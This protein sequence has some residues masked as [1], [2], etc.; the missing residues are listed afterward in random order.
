[1]L[2]SSLVLCSL[3]IAIS[4]NEPLPEKV[5][6]VI[7]DL[8]VDLGRK[9]FK[10]WFEQVYPSHAE[11]K[12]RILGWQLDA[13]S[14]FAL[15]GQ[16]RQPL[17]LWL[18]DGHPMGATSEHGR[19]IRQALADD[20]LV[21]WLNKYS[22]AADDFNRTLDLI[23]V[24][25]GQLAVYLPNG[26]LL[27][28]E[29]ATTPQELL[30]FLTSTL[31]KYES[32]TDAEKKIESDSNILD[33]QPRAENDFPDDGLSL[34]VFKRSA[35]SLV[36]DTFE[37]STW[38]KDF[39]WFNTGEMQDFVKPIK[40]SSKKKLPDELAHRIVESFALAFSAEDLHKS[41]LV[42]RCTS[43]R[44]S[45]STYLISGVVNYQNANGV[46]RVKMQ[47]S[48]T[49]DSVAEQFG[50][51]EIVALG[52]YVSSANDL[53]LFATA[54]RKVTSVDGWHRVPPKNLADYA[55][56]YYSNAS[57]KPNK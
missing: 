14:G 8:D 50:V 44:G 51:L 47:G 45:R 31:E 1:M 38:H 36:L 54:L 10:P 21:P 46:L 33:G 49:Y 55:D 53:R 35:N 18:E 24:D 3:F 15:A 48:A 20:S 6:I 12:W 16:S 42:F 22:L 4:C 56:A 27:A 9:N 11:L 25:E 30:I 57:G 43:I 29:L 2:R 41:E 23:N 5:D 13:Q 37:S 40:I 39:I 32:L 34:E 26:T 19:K 28:S 17:L 7:D 52:E